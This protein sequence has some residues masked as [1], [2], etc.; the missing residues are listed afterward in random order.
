MS[1]QRFWLAD[2]RHFLFG[3]ADSSPPLH[4]SFLVGRQALSLTVP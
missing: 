3:M 1:R 2:M 4:A